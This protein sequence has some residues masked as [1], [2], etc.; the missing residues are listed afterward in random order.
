MDRPAPDIHLIAPPAT[1]EATLIIR[2]AGQRQEWRRVVLDAHQLDYYDLAPL[3]PGWGCWAHE[4]RYLSDHTLRHLNYLM[5]PRG[6]Q[7]EA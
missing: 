5:C 1:G 4:G 7:P 6:G 2:E 3:W